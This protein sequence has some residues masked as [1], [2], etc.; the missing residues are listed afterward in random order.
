MSE[1]RRCD[2]NV[3][4]SDSSQRGSRLSV[5]PRKAHIET[6]AITSISSSFAERCDAGAQVCGFLQ[7]SRARRGKPKLCVRR[8][9]IAYELKPVLNQGCRN[10]VEVQLGSF[11]SL[12]S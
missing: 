7:D 11:D 3:V 9:D 5:R 12:L 1:A 4:L 8:L 6:G 10:R 2:R